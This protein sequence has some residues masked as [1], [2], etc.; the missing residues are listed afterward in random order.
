MRGTSLNAS[1]EGHSSDLQQ[2]DEILASVS[3]AANALLQTADW[4][5]VLS[6]VLKRLGRSSRANRAYFFRKH[7]RPSDGMILVSQVA[8]WVADGIDP[9]IKNPALQDF[10]LV[11]AGL[12]RWLALMQRRQPV[13]GLISGFPANEREIFESQQIQ[14]LVAMPVFS[15]G[16]LYGFLGFDDCETL[17]SWSS[18]ELDALSAAAGVMGAAIDRQRLESQLRFAQKMEAIGGLASGVAHDFNNILHA[19]TT[20]TQLALEKLPGEG[21]PKEELESV[22]VATQRATELTRQLLIFARKQ[23]IQPRLLDLGNVCES[24]LRILRPGLGV[25]TELATSIEIPAPLVY[26]DDGLLSQV[27]LNLCL[28]ASDAMPDG[29]ELLVTCEAKSVSEQEAQRSPNAVP[30]EYAV[31]RVRDNGRGMHPATRERIFEPFF[32]T[33]E[34]GQGTGLGLSLA[35]STVT[36]CGGFIE[37][38]SEPGKGSEFQ[39]YLPRATATSDS[40]SASNGGDA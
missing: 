11:E 2:R 35:F 30:G 39:V 40:Q 20:L 9:Q 24:V 29:G 1:G 15:E 32:T 31:M 22:L 17:R 21:S 14:S 19:V 34:A 36:Q 33:K 6:S 28:N 23:E 7:V 18:A 16:Q 13:V 27:L 4:R 3:F 38:S 12:G 8:E 10:P 26:A 5:E 37:V 25:K